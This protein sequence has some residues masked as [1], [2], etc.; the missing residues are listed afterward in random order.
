MTN[1]VA[2]FTTFKSN[3]VNTFKYPPDADIKQTFIDYDTI[4]SAV[5]NAVEAS[6]KVAM[7]KGA[8]K[9]GT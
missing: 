3:R 9:R 1:F 6:V 4:I 7:S 5:K 2:T 8:I